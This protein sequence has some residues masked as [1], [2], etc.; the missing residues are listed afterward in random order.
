[1]KEILNND[2]L[3]GVCWNEEVRRLFDVLCTRLCSGLTAQAKSTDALRG[4][5]AIFFGDTI[6]AGWR[7]ACGE[8]DLTVGGRGS[9]YK[10]SKYNVNGGYAH[11]LAR[12]SAG[13][14]SVPTA[15]LAIT[16]EAYR[17]HK[18]ETGFVFLR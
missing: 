3:K 1:M 14:I 5:K 9:S 13:A 12:H 2:R 4:K 8:K 6:A 11:R 7:D 17:K 10:I 18:F 16:C 15:T